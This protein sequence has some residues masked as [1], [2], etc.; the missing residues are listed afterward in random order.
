MTCTG[1]SYNGVVSYR[2]D[3]YYNGDSSYNG[4]ASYDGSVSLV[5]VYLVL[6]VHFNYN[7]GLS[8]NGESGIHFDMRELQTDRQTQ[9]L[10]FIDI[11]NQ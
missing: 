7:G 3:A 5:V 11:Y 9:S 6:E 2:G 1:V 10:Y 8:Y 4:D